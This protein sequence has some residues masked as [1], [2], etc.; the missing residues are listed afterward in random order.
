MA[1]TYVEIDIDKILYNI[2]TIRFI[3]KNAMFCAVVKAN[4]YGLGA[5]RIANEIEDEVDY[6]AVARVSEAINLRKTGITKP[7]L[8]LGYVS[9]DDINKCRDFK[10]EFPVYDLAY[11]KRINEKLSGPTDVHI[12]LDTGHSR[13]GFREFEIEKIKKLNTLENLNIISAFTHYATADEVDQSFTIL[14]SK[15]YYDIR[16]QI[17]DTF[18]FKF[19]HISN[20]AAS[21]KYKNLKD[22]ARIGISLYGIYPSDHIKDS[23]DVKLQQ[24]FCLKSEVSFVKTVAKNTPISYGRSYV[25]DKET[26]IATISIG[27]AD[28]YPR[29]LSN[30]GLVSIHGVG[31]RVLGRVCMDQLMV[32]ASGLDVRIGDEVIVYPNVYEEAKKANTIAYELM[33]SISM[34]VPRIYKKNGKIITIDN[35][36]GEI[37]EN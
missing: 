16:G 22:M 12:G 30:Q 5:S 9:I 1:D 6:F 14:Q 32:D 34:R 10:I 15:R 35:Y 33:T 25:T 28:G 37:N 27:Y 11:A 20:S 36:L 31:C 23:T 26:Q 13:L 3:D 8:V 29:I 7:V 17:D 19:L 24:C 21:I 2:E 4:G 18:D